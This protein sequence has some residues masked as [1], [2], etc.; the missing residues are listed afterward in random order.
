MKNNWQP[1]SLRCEDFCGHN[2][3]IMGVNFFDGDKKMVSCASESIIR[4]WDI[5]MKKE[6]RSLDHGGEGFT[7]E[8]CAVKPN[9]HD[10]DL[11]LSCGGRFIDA[12]DFRSSRRI[13]S[14]DSFPEDTVFNDV[15]W[16]TQNS[17]S[18]ASDAALYLFDMRN[19]KII[20]N[21]EGCFRATSGSVN[22]RNLWGGSDST[23]YLFDTLD[24]TKKPKEV[25]LD[26]NANDI[27]T[28]ICIGGRFG[29]IVFASHFDGYVSHLTHRPK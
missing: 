19:Q 10:S 22:G 8:V 20:L 16:V 27:I 23:L 25:N 28:R 1:E 21:S 2:S 9:L 18:G 26:N 12:W 15:T 13:Y 24:L 5:E 14:F 17:L 4:V 6:I 11:F 7:G 29:E 3:I